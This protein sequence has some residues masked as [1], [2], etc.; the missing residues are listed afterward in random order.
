MNALIATSRVHI[1]AGCA[2]TVEKVV[3]GWGKLGTACGKVEGTPDKPGDNPQVS[4]CYPPDM[5]LSIHSHRGL[6][7]GKMGVFPSIHTPYCGEDIFIMM[8]FKVRE[9][10]TAAQPSRSRP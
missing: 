9:A 10:T 3:D 8:G 7:A 6:L 2:Q 1:N 5:P 4:K